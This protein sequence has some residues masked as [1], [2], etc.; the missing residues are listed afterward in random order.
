MR[1]LE[2]LSKREGLTV[3]QIVRLGINAFVGQCHEPF[4]MAAQQ[5][6]EKNTELYRRLL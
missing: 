1:K 6:M 2:E 5:V 3:K 4:R